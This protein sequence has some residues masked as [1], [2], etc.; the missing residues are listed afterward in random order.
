MTQDIISK[1]VTLRKQSIN[2]QY[3][4]HR[5]CRSVLR[6]TVYNTKEASEEAGVAGP[7]HR[8]AA[9]CL[10]EDLHLPGG[11]FQPNSLPVSSHP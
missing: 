2:V 10:V 11:G 5:C 6:I 7:S 3:K 4:Q 9:R 1:C 8:R